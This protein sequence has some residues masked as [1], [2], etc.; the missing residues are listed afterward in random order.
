MKIFIYL[1]VVFFILFFSSR[2][3][4]DLKYFEK[5]SISSELRFHANV[6]LYLF[7]FIKI[8]GINFKEDGIHLL[9]FRIKYKKFEFN[10]NNMKNYISK[11]NLKNLNPKIEKLDLNL[12]VGIEDVMLT[13]FLIFTIATFVAVLSAKY[14]NQINMKNYNYRI[15][16]SY[17]V[18]M[19]GIKLSC[20]ISENILNLIKTIMLFNKIKQR[21]NIRSKYIAENQLQI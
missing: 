14:R 19:L 3:K 11:D 9:F 8:F 7:G 17:N 10:K 20:K 13:A 12:N 21:K 5:N 15:I 16:P 2:L 1:L 6:G 4:L 18:N